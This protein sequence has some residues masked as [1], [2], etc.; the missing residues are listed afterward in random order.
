MARYD[1]SIFKQKTIRNFELIHEDKEKKKFS[2]KLIFN[3]N[4]YILGDDKD[5]SINIHDSN[6]HNEKNKVTNNSMKNLKIISNFNHKKSKNF[7]THH[8]Q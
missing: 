7:S 1:S 5:E 8:Q 2:K 4:K 3:K 6:N